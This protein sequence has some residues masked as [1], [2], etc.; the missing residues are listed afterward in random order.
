[1]QISAAAVRG[2]LERKLEGIRFR[3]ANLCWNTGEANKGKPSV[4]ERDPDP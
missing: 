4:K 3:L 1:M 2:R